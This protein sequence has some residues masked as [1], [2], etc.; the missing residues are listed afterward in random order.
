MNKDRADLIRIIESLCRGGLPLNFVEE[1]AEFA[2]T[3]VEIW[4]EQVDEAIKDLRDFVGYKD[5]S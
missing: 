4:K 3:R 5:E 2:V 1:I